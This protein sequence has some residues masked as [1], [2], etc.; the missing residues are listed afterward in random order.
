[1]SVVAAVAV[2]LAIALRPRHAR[3]PLARPPATQ[4]ERP[5][6]A[7]SRRPGFVSGA[8]NGLRRDDLS[9][10]PPQDVADALVLLVFALRSGLSITDAV[11]GVASTSIGP[12]RRDLARVV[13]ALGWGVGVADAWADLGT[14]WRPAALAF[15]MAGETGA[16]PS[17]LLAVGLVGNVVLL[18]YVVVTDPAS[19]L[20]CAG[21]VGLGGVLYVLEKVFGTKNPDSTGTGAVE[22]A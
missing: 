3:W 8:G 7:A 18:G 10:P 5:A 19:L 1:M 12:V 21:L 11:S 17:A 22:G 16:S 14:V 15:T 4:V 9:R 20:W 2:L 6:T 13:A